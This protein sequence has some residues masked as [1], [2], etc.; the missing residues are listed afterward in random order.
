ML[1]VNQS[2]AR[3]VAVAFLA[4]TLASAG[5]TLAALEAR[6]DTITTA[7]KEAIVIDF[8][9]GAILLDKNAD[10][11]MVPSSMSKLMT[12][13]LVFERLKQGS[14]KLTD[15]LPVSET[16]WKRSNWRRRRF[17]R[18]TYRA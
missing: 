14:L 6:A 8:D 11:E 9:T 18:F 4:G 15:K 12:V 1:I 3:R 5:L 7:A 10:E 16:A 17:V 13:Y 2:F